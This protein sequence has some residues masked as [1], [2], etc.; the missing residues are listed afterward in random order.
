[1]ELQEIATISSLLGSDYRR[2][3]NYFVAQLDPGPGWEWENTA[4]YGS[5]L[6]FT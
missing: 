1:L 2:W 6:R 5:I 3:P 4:R